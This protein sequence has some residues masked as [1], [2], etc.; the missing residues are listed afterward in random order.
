MKENIILSAVYYNGNGEHRDMIPFDAT[1][2]PEAR[3]AN[4]LLYGAQKG[5]E[6]VEVSSSF[7]A[8]QGGAY[9]RLQG[10]NTIENAV[11]HEWDYPQ[12]RDD[13]VAEAYQTVLQSGVTATQPQDIYAH[14]DAPRSPN[15]PEYKMY[16]S[17]MRAVDREIMKMSD[18]PRMVDELSQAGKMKPE[19]A[20]AW[21][22]SGMSMENRYRRG[23]NF[24]SEMMHNMP[25]QFQ[26]KG[27]EMSRNGL[28]FKASAEIDG[29]L[30]K[31]AWAFDS[32]GVYE[33]GA[34]TKSELAGKLVDDYM[35]DQI[36]KDYDA[37]QRGYSIETNKKGKERVVADMVVDGKKKHVDFAK[38]YGPY[39]LQHDDISSLLQGKEITI[40]LRSGDATVKLGEGSY[41]G[42]A[43]FGVQRTDLP[44]KGRRIPD[45][46][47]ATQSS[48][49][50]DKQVGE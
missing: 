8:S 36:K 15:L 34:P 1:E 23:G 20:K 18:I 46:G 2:N 16:T 13:K 42:H 25:E 12:I 50:A 41:M 22:F 9:W 27:V 37:M 43:Y 40:P 44:E 4:A 48:P 31:G 11:S 5:Y 10:D 30:V 24:T 35:A 3:I 47:D 21:E 19:L 32:K 45:V 28:N 49:T 26:P 33:Y 17:D 38:Q 29:K 39:D 7:I 14:L 6:N